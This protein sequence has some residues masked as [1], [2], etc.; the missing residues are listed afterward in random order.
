MMLAPMQ[1]IE[2]VSWA[3]V[4][5]RF[6]HQYVFLVW[7]VFVCW[8]FKMYLL[9]LEDGLS[10]GLVGATVFSLVT[11]GMFK[12]RPPDDGMMLPRVKRVW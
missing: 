6:S 9:E 5:L 2:R 4:Y 3:G 8:C 12:A 10:W 7:G 1:H 11:A